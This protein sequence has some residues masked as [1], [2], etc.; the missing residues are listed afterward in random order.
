MVYKARFNDH[1]NDF[2]TDMNVLK[3]EDLV[4]YKSALF[5]FNAKNKNLP[6]NLQNVLI[7]KR[8]NIITRHRE[9]FQQVSVR[10]T[11]K[12]NSLMVKRD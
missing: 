10:T 8:G 4:M 7:E 5:M 12:D 6:A 3:L 9:T 11:F 1:T 2:F